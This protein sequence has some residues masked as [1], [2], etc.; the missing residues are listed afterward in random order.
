MKRD[1]S[2]F[3]SA[4]AD[5][6]SGIPAQQFPSLLDYWMLR[7]ADARQTEFHNAKG[8]VLVS[9]R[10]RRRPFDSDGISNLR[11]RL[12]AHESVVLRSGKAVRQAITDSRGVELFSA[13]THP[14]TFAKGPRL[15]KGDSLALNICNFHIPSI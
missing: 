12:R 13:P 8:A 4:F 2:T 9:F 15:S 10:L 1:R 6:L 7:M 5:A 14:S 3:D 11:M